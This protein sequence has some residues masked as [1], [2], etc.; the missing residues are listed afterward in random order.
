MTCWRSRELARVVLGG[1]GSSDVVTKEGLLRLL[2]ATG[3]TRSEMRKRSAAKSCG[4]P[5]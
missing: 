2:N 1:A 3:T 5:G 4:A